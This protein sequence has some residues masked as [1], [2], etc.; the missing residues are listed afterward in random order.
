MKTAVV[1]DYFT[2]LGGAEKVAEEIYRMFPEADLFATVALPGRMPESLEH[3]SV[4]TSWMQRL[5]GLKTYYRLYFLLYPLAVRALNLTDYDLVLSSSSGYAKGV[6]TSSNAVH[7]CY[8]HTPMRWVWNFD[9]YAKRESFSLGERTILPALIEGLRKWDEGASRQPDHFIA[10]SKV[11]AERIRR[12][13]GRASEVIHPPI[14]IQRFRTSRVQED[15]Y[16]VLS[17]LVPYKRID[18]AVEACTRLKRNLIVIGTGPDRSTLEAIAGPT[19]KF[20]GRASDDDV[21]Y[22]VSRGRA[23]IFP[24]EEDFGMAPLEVAAA[25]RPTI[26][27]RAGGAVETIIEGRTGLFFNEQTT[28]DL[29]EAIE[30]FEKQDW[31]TSVLRRHAEN[32]S[33]EVFQERFNNF[34]NRVGVPTVPSVAEIFARANAG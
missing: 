13:Y 16:V 24:G 21:E 4:N 10:N 31:P 22:Y 25:G 1:H 30:N 14:D 32:Y 9:G 33:V 12:V 34:L 15:F 23:L 28:E 6:R 27:Y 5:P 26:A 18:L 7:I 2:Q 11:V 3:V 29:M 19:V 20:L 17:R 8:C